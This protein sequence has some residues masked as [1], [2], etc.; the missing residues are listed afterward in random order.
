MAVVYLSL[1]STD[2]SMKKLKLKYVSKAF[3]IGD[4]IQ[5][6]VLGA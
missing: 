4:D 1:I 6:F 5:A 2:F 3:V